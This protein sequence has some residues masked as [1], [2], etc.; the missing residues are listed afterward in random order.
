MSNGT[1]NETCF[2][3]VKGED[4]FTV[5]AAETWSIAMIR[6]LHK[7][8]PGEV[9]IRH[10]NPDGSMVVSLPFDW[11]RIVP[12]KRLALSDQE[13]QV[14]ANRLTSRRTAVQAKSSQVSHE[15]TTSNTGTYPDEKEA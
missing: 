15:S 1:L 11:M 7:E 9:N 13:K 10:T 14:R 2:D 12:K 8:R 3:H 4:F 5:T 6:R